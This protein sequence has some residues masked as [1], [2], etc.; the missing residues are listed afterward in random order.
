MLGI[1]RP[2][3]PLDGRLLVELLRIIQPVP[4]NP[5]STRGQQVA[6]ATRLP[7]LVALIDFLISLDTSR[8]S[9]KSFAYH[10]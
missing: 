1:N 4:F 10:A 6:H 5:R 8:Y 9:V 3:A 7:A 2:L